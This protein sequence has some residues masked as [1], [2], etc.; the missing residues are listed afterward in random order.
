MAGDTG[1]SDDLKD[2]EIPLETLLTLFRHG[3]DSETLCTAIRAL[4]QQGY[5][6]ERLTPA[7]YMV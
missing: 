1:M 3:W 4:R 7:K 5:H 6:I 2:R